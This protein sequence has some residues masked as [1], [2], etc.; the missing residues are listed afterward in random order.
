M[1][2]QPLC[3]RT[4]CTLLLRRP[5]LTQ[6]VIPVV[7]GLAPPRQKEL[8]HSLLK[9]EHL[10]HFF[11]FEAKEKPFPKAL[12][13]EDCV[14]FHETCYMVVLCFQAYSWAWTLWTCYMP[15]EPASKFCISREDIFKLWCRANKTSKQTRCWESW[16]ACC[17]LQ[18]IT[19]I[20]RTRLVV[21]V[22]LCNVH[23]PLDPFK[24]CN[25]FISCKC[26]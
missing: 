9:P 14:S 17:L 15:A 3:L 23:N 16:Q 25:S 8:A 18:N 2:A 24:V 4:T 13:M 1:T 5:G 26:L 10:A 12:F 7:S 19:R 20:R 21:V 11:C 22:C 6:P